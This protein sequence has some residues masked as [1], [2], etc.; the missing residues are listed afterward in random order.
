MTSEV[1]EELGKRKKK[2]RKR[3]LLYSNIAETGRPTF[4]ITHGFIAHNEVSARQ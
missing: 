4:A 3:S 2:G 1:G